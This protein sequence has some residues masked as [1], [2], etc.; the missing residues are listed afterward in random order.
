MARMA[1]YRQVYVIYASDKPLD[2]KDLHEKNVRVANTK[3][4][5]T[6]HTH[7]VQDE[8]L[9]PFLEREPGV[10]LTDQYAPVDNLMADVFRRR[11]K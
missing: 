5:L 6:F 10:I 2:V 4:I 7:A 11:N 8:L 3:K 1:Q 9:W